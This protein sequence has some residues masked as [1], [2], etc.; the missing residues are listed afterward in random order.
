M[1]NSTVFSLFANEV[2]KQSYCLSK[3]VYQHTYMYVAPP[4]GGALSL[5][6]YSCEDYL[7]TASE[8]CLCTASERKYTICLGAHYE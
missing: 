1:F 8:D 6:V 7:C 2:L 4:D 3:V 5:F